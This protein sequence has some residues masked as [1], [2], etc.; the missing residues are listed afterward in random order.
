[1]ISFSRREILAVSSWTK[2]YDNKN[3]TRLENY[4]DT[5]AVIRYIGAVSHEF[6]VYGKED[7]DDNNY[8]DDVDDDDSDN[9][10]DGHSNDDDDDDGHDGYDNDDDGC[11]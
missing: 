1:M 5:Y 8:D 6:I 9:D 10:D 4:C 3:N 7:E 2:F 11:C